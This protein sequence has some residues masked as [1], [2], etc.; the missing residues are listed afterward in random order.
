MR[1]IIV[2]KEFS[3]HAREV[4]EWQEEFEWRTGREA[5]GR[6]GIL[7]GARGDGIPDDFGDGGRRKSVGRMERNAATAD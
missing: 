5:E 7:Y 1:V 6:G 3:D 2:F 4:F